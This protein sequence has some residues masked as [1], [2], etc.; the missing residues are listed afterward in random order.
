VGALPVFCVLASAASLL[1]AAVL[2]F[3]FNDG[4]TWRAHRLAFDAEGK[5]FLLQSGSRDAT[6]SIALSDIRHVTLKEI[7]GQRS[8]RQLRFVP[9]LV[10]PKIDRT[11]QHVE[12][13]QWASES[14]AKDLVHALK[15][16]V[17]AVRS[18]RAATDARRWASA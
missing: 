18:E 17:D 13:V 9:T 7:G 2:L 16:C 14:D 12:L 15:R 11:P 6:R 5:R 8:W 10:L 3:R 1:F 4:Q